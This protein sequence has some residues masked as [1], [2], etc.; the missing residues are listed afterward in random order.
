MR[1]HFLVASLLL[2]TPAFGLTQAE[3]G[4]RLFFDKRLSADRSVSCATC[5]IPEKAF[6]NGRRLA[7]GAFHRTG[8]RNVPTLL[9]RHGTGPQFWDMRAPSLEAQALAVLANAKEMGDDLAGAVARINSDAN[10]RRDFERLFGGTANPQNVASALAAFQ[11]TLR[12]PEAPYDRF[13]KGDKNALSAAAKHGRELFFGKFNCVSCHSG[14]NFSD[15]KLNVRC[16]PFVANLEAVVGP[17]F[18]TPTLRNLSFTGPYMHNGALKTLEET[19]DFYNPSIQL[20]AQGKPVPNGHAVY[21]NESDKKNLVAFLKSLSAK[22][23]F[24]EIKD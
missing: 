20:N 14:P 4:K 12:A 8:D 6:T 5:H 19:I 10:Y 13:V 9:N 16:Y 2:S 24:E 7:I 15:E 1:V 21:V 22:K 23:P 11:R 3:L 17:R 18:K